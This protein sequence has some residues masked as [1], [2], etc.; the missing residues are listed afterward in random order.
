V[1]PIHLPISER[2]PRRWIE[3][4]RA[5]SPEAPCPRGYL[6]INHTFHSQSFVCEWSCKVIRITTQPIALLLVITTY[7]M[8]YDQHLELCFMPLSI[9]DCLF[10]RIYRRQWSSTRIN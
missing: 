3:P 1:V 6:V 8:F 10:E 9:R 2:L 5:M 4:P 7:S